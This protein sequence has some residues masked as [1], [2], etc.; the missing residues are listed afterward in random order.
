MQSRKL[1]ASLVPGLAT[2][3]FATTV[4]SDTPIVAERQMWWSAGNAYGS[5]AEQAVEA[6]ASKW[7]FAERRKPTVASNCSICF[8]TLAT[9]SRKSVY[10]IFRPAGAAPREGIPP[11]AAV[12]DEHLGGC[13]AVRWPGSAHR[14][15]CVRG[16]RSDTWPGDHCRTGHVFLA[17]RTRRPSLRRWPRSR[18]R[19]GTSDRMVPRR[20]S[21]RRLFRPVRLD[22]QSERRAGR[23]GGNLPPSDGTCLAQASRLGDESLQHLGRPGRRAGWPTPRSPRS[24]GHST[25]CRSWSNAPCGGRDPH[26]RHGRRL[27]SAAGVRARRPDGRWPMV[28]CRTLRPRQTRTCS[29]RIQALPMPP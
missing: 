4:E 3:E 2:G 10:G 8:R 29:S 12:A 23:G 21:D 15:R 24:F 5:H 18:R 28:S 6:P 20:R 25:A 17:C 26:R 13:R 1:V 11:G 7:Y 27:T 9:A 19:H 16:D 22:C 14:G